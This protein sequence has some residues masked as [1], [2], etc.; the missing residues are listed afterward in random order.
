VSDIRILLIIAQLDFVPLLPAVFRNADRTSS[1][2]IIH[3]GDGEAAHDKI[4]KASE[5]SEQPVLVVGFGKSAVDAAV[6]LGRNGR[7]C[8]LAIKKPMFFMGMDAEKPPP[9]KVVQ[10]RLMTY[11]WPAR[12]LTT[13]WER[14]L[15]NTR[16]GVWLVQKFFDLLVSSSFKVQKLDHGHVLRCKPDDVFWRFQMGGSI[17]SLDGNFFD[18]VNE[19]KVDI[20]GPTSIASLDGHTVKFE[21]G[22]SLDVSGIICATGWENSWLSLFDKDE[23]HALGLTRRPPSLVIPLVQDP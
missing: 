23:A 13:K 14:F 10:S 17:P 8:A 1:P 3:S 21:N 4:L 22:Q 12:V 18:L 9:L 2:I 15:H 6:F 16:V 19:G 7:K 20:I 11:F 5:G